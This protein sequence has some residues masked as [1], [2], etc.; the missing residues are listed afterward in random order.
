[1]DAKNNLQEFY[2]GGINAL[3]KKLNTSAQGLSEKAAAAALQKHGLNELAEKK[4]EPLLVKIFK[5]LSEPMVLILLAASALSLFIQDYIEGAAILGVVLIN[6]LIGLWQD[7]KAENAVDALRKMLAP[8]A[9]VLRDGKME[10]VAAAR[11]ARGDIL[12]FEA[13]DIVPADCR[14]ISGQD[15]MLDEAHLTGESKSIGKKLVD[16]KGEKKL[17]EMTN[18]LFA[19]SR[20]INGAGQAVVFA[21][22]RATQM[23]LIAQ[24]IAEAAEEKTPLQRKLDRETV[25]LVEAAFFAALAAA[26][27]GFWH[28]GLAA[29]HATTLIAVSV[30]V[31]VFPEGLPAS[32]SIALS[33]AV[34]RL[35][36][37]SVIIKKLV[38]VETLGNVDYICTDKTGTITQHVMTVKEY[39]I[40]GRYQSSAEILAMLADGD[41]ELIND[42]FETAL[43][44]STASLVEKDGTIQQ[45]IGDPTETALL[46]SA[47]LSGFKAETLLKTHKIQEMLPFS[48]DR[49]YSAARV[50]ESNG[51]VEVYLKGAP[52]KILALCDRWHD[53]AKTLPL[54]PK[55]FL[56]ELAEKSARGFRLIGF[57][58]F[59]GK[60]SL[61]NP[62]PHG[63]FLGAAVIYDP[64]K[65]EVKQV[66]KEAQAAGVQ[67]VMITGDSKKTGFSIAEHVG[68]ARK[69]TQ[70]AEGKD[71]EKY[72]EARRAKVVENLRVY[73]RVAPL[74][75]LD[76]VAAL[77]A[78]KHIVAM[79]GDGVNDAPALKKADVGIAMG[80]AGT[81]V[82]QEAADIILTDDNFSTIVHA[83]REGRTVYSNLKKLIVYL[84]TNNIGKVLAILGLPLFGFGAPLLP[85]QILWSNVVMESLPSVAISTDGAAADI[86][87]RQPSRLDE[88]LIRPD[89]RRRMFADGLIFGVM[90]AL[91]FLAA[92]FINALPDGAASTAFHT[93]YQLAY[94][95]TAAF[96]IALLSPQIYSFALRD[97]NLWQKFFRPNFLLKLFF[98]LNVFVT[99]AI[100][101]VRPL[102]VVFGT[103]PLDNYYILAV[104]LVCSLLPSL[105]RLAAGRNVK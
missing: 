13:G 26:A 5:S 30:I 69:I 45:E 94:A 6:T 86:M 51:D 76:I 18:I 28:G 47:Y 71:W 55:Q 22:G 14:L 32:I 4:S 66:I 17:Y 38:S 89:E 53:G 62:A 36:K 39:F 75:K 96:V 98:V 78:N 74:D 90:I 85:L 60:V 88:P 8:Q 43:T 33:L 80:K 57:A 87:R 99:W 31:S 59:T 21:T 72:S 41:T 91:G 7:A 77:K 63:V 50:L 56:A 11:L 68:I 25:F 97:G 65:D 34:E 100:V 93:R 15:I 40:K 12:C 67:V 48:S 1:M 102:N 95:Q 24:N 35:A 16:L 92:W 79:T 2:S 27:L 104:V 103:V 70:V 82:A 49:M 3:Y 61:T 37:K 58:K 10:I 54:K 19:G 105:V 81:Q 73:S 23:G 46:K 29:W 83:V 44:A 42:V 52:E 9:K 84:I 20:V 101:Y 64:P